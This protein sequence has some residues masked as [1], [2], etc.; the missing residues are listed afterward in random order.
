M[1]ALFKYQRNIETGPNGAVLDFKNSDIE[2]GPRA[3]YLCEVDGW[4]YVSV[5][6]GLEMPAQPEGI[7]WQAVAEPSAALIEQLKRSARPVSIA[8]D[9]VRRRIELEV[10]DVHDMVADSM[11]LC[12]FAIALSVRVS[13][14][15][16]TGEQ[17]DPAVREAYTDRVSTVKEALDSGAIV[18]RSDLEDPTQMMQRLMTRYTKINDLIAESYKPAVDELL[19]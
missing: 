12:E 4:R 8:K 17:M 19:P 5:P 9:V 7:Q 10:G 16:L 3:T 2:D 11:R 1:P 15:V 6:D 14:E 13:H 18:L